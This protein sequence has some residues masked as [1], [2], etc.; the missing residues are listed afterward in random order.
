METVAGAAADDAR[1]LI[2]DDDA[3]VGRAFHRLIGLEQPATHALSGRE[4]RA[5]LAGWSR[6]SGF[7]IDLKLGDCSGL[8]ILRLARARHPTVPAMM[9][10][11]APDPSVINEVFALGAA[12]ACKPATASELMGFVSR[13][14]ARTRRLGPGPTAMVEA[15]A[16]AH[17]LSRREVELL[18]L[19]V[20]GAS[21]AELKT[22]MSIS[23]NTLKTHTRS[24]LRKLNASDLSEVTI[25]VLRGALES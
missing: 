17:A 8:E 12:F 11:A 20:G 25:Q 10:T 7:F 4:A 9:I 22:G 16:R 5:A 23:E 14:L 18:V 19:A 1:W 2:V 21:R 13:C 3:A 15:L 6:W 24:L